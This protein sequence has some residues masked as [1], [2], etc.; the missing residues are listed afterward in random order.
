MRWTVT[1]LAALLLLGCSSPRPLVG[2]INPQKPVASLPEIKSHKIF[3]A[4]TRKPSD[5]PAIFYSK[6]RS[7]K[8]SFAAVNVSIPPNHEPGKIERPSGSL[9]DP[10]KDMVIYKA[11]HLEDKENFRSSINEELAKRK[12]SERDVLIF[13]HGYNTDTTGAVLRLAQ[14]VE[15]TD[16]PGIAV[17]FTWA[18]HANPRR[19]VYDINSAI[20][21]RDGL[22]ETL[23]VFRRVNLDGF[24]VVA[25]SMG[26]L[27]TME[28]IRQMQIRSGFN[29]S[30]LLKNVILASP[31]IDIDVFASQVETIPP[32]DRNFY[33]L[34]SSDDKALRL[35]RRIAGGVTRVGNAPPERL[36]EL[37]VAV[38]DLSK[39]GDRSNLNHSKFAES[40]EMVQLLGERF[41]AGDRL[42]TSAERP[43]AAILESSP[44]GITV[45]LTQ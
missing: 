5:D 40:P 45:N 13:V 7:Q 27:L 1:V 43:I 2:V 8:L 12:H 9:P 22:E 37:G 38:I 6:D 29:R 42:D 26:N 10:H 30:P 39:I 41:K 4:T 25:H 24:D 44:I 3:V 33:V 21:A 16:Y 17:L 19:Y 14:F 23:E 11:E 36:Q 20:Q 32:K 34:V 35:S 15:D 28:T 18:S 31:D